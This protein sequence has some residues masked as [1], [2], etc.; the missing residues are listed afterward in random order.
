MELARRLN[1]EIVCADS[2]TL[3]K[4]MDIG[5]AKPSISDQQEI[6]HHLLDVIEPYERFSVA[7]F[8]EMAN[9][10]I[11]DI[12]SRGKLPIVVGGTGLYI[13][14]LF[15]DFNVT[16]DS[17]N[18]EYKNELENMSVLN[19]QKIIVDKNYPMPKNENN[20]R[21]LVGVILREG[22]VNENFK[23]ILNARI[24]GLLP[25]DNVIKS[26][27]TARVNVMFESGL[28]NEVEGLIEEY[29][30]PP[31]KLDAICYPIINRLI[32]G[33]IDQTEA[34]RLFIQADWQY[35]RR[36]KSW[37]K[38]NKNIVWFKEVNTAFE[39]ILNEIQ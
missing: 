25:E 2:Q 9:E 8:K 14:A 10:A 12:K 37:F 21:H 5:T 29:G 13:D 27:I 32:N 24:Y 31:A 33:E 4:R 18:S 26:R 1:G 7:M 17:K 34:K 6:K 39:Y 3:R 19:L 23:P 15:Y 20:P 38:R 28:V 35:A 30:Q 36:Q 11:E 16:V 22:K